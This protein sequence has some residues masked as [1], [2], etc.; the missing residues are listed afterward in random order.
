MH[1]EKLEVF[2][3]LLC[4]ASQTHQHLSF[5]AVLQ[6]LSELAPRQAHLGQHCCKP[7]PGWAH[8][9]TRQ[10]QD[11]FVRQTTH[12]TLVYTSL[13]ESWCFMTQQF[14]IV[15][16]KEQQRNLYNTLFYEMDKLTGRRENWPS[17]LSLGPFYSQFH[18]PC[19]PHLPGIPTIFVSILSTFFQ[20]FPS[21]F[22]H[23]LTKIF[24][25]SQ[26]NQSLI[27]QYFC[28]FNLFQQCYLGDKPVNHSKDRSK[29]SQSVSLLKSQNHSG[30]KKTSKINQS[31]I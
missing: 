5:A 21:T 11:S 22:Y 8:K 26:V 9:L 16:I 31:N 20:F 4:S 25:Y 23:L 13:F 2:H 24:H 12:L 7:C 10:G 27:S 28:S 6:F 30:W 18:R 14:I 29:G 1:P 17:C 15:E 19:N 3:R